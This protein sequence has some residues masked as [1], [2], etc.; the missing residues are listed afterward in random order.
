MF[1]NSKSPRKQFLLPPNWEQSQSMQP[2]GVFASEEFWFKEMVV[3][4]PHL[5]CF[6]RKYW[7]GF[8]TC[9]KNCQLLALFLVIEFQFLHEC[10]T[11]DH[12]FLNQLLLRSSVECR[13]VLMVDC[14]GERKLKVGIFTLK[15]VH[16]FSPFLYNS[17]KFSFKQPFFPGFTKNGGE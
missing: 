5:S 3:P 16:W 9:G 6:C 8:F 14:C 4:W 7:R 15:D 11:K 10:T 17:S 12:N 2:L 1:Y 13:G